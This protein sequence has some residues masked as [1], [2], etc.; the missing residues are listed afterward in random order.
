MENGVRV[1]YSDSKREER[2]REGGQREGEREFQIEEKPMRRRRP[3]AAADFR[4]GGGNGPLE[5][6]NTGAPYCNQIC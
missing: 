6:R 3:I 4:T 5:P 1:A 2:E